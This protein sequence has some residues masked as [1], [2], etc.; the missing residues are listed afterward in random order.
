MSD[1]PPR[2]WVTAA[3]K[4]GKRKPVFRELVFKADKLALRKLTIIH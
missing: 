3:N 2:F 1:L 4:M